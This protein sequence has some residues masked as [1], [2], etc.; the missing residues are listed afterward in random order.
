MVDGLKGLLNEPHDVLS[1]EDKTQQ[2]GLLIADTGNDCLRVAKQESANKWMVV[3]P[4][5]EGVPDNRM[6]CKGGVCKL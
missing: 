1:Y 2:F 5:I 6:N 4:V 3:T